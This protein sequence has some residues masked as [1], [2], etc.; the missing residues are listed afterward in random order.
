MLSDEFSADCTH[1]TLI[2][3]GHQS[4]I[5]VTLIHLLISALYT[6]VYCEAL[7]MSYRVVKMHVAV[8]YPSGDIWERAQ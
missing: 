4:H 3:Y 5:N 1:N 8:M 2:A 6:C 7:A